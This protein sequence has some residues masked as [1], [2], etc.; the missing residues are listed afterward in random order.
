MNMTATA[1]T[2][3]ASCRLDPYGESQ[4]TGRMQSGA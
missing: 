3:T 2:A 1:P 4:K